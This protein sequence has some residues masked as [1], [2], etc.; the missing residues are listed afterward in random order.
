MQRKLF[1]FF[2]PQEAEAS[3][4]KVEKEPQKLKKNMLNFYREYLLCLQSSASS[5]FLETCVNFVEQ[6]AKFS[7][8]EGRIIP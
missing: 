5:S 3:G 2:L 8:V 7:H 4:N 1:L 6:R